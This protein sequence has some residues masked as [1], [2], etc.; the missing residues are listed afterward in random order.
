[1]WQSGEKSTVSEFVGTVLGLLIA[2][3]IGLPTMGCRPTANGPETSREETTDSAADAN[4]K[5][6]PAS[7]VTPQGAIR[8]RDVSE[9]TGI[10]FLHVDGSA[11]LR[12]IVESM[13]GGVATLDYDG[14]GLIDIY[15]PNGSTL[16]G[17]QPIQPPPRHALYRN[18]GDWKFKDVTVEAGIDCTTFGMGVTVGDFDN[19]G[20]PDIF[21]SNFGPNLLWHNNGDGTFA[22]IRTPFDRGVS[23]HDFSYDGLVGAGTSFVDVDSD[24]DL[25]LYVGNYLRLNCADH[26][27]RVFKGIPSY[28][29]PRDYDPVPDELFRNNG[30]GTFSDV[31]ESSG[32]A[33]HPGRAMGMIAADYDNDHDTD[34]FVCND[35]QQN[36]LFQ[37]DGTGHFEEVAALAGVAYNGNGQVLANMGV[38]AADYN[39]DGL[40][41]FFTTNYQGTVPVLFENLGGG[42]LTDVTAGT[43][44]GSGCYQDVNWG[45]GFA[46]LDNDGFKDLFIGNGHTEDNIEERMSGA[47]YHSHYIVLK[48]DGSKFVNVSDRCSDGSQR[49][50]A[51]KGLAIDDLDND[52]DPDLVVMASRESPMMLR[53]MYGE[54][55]GKHHWL[56]IQLIGVT[57]NRDGVGARVTV[58]VGGAELVD[59]VHSGRSYQ[60]HSGMRLHFGLGTEE[61]VEQVEVRWMGGGR[62]L[63]K[64]VAADQLL[65]IVQ[66]NG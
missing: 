58:T 61:Q 20:A 48:N 56:E 14:D 54:S 43:N 37:N 32:I 41:D 55:G 64:N 8:L 60:S 28:P 7:S 36:F 63:I 12:Y 23:P 44:A 57:G 47:V 51:A 45:C 62:Q 59:E 2:T 40:L 10:D 4:A 65:T 6:S 38:D 42:L 27:P 52:G 13:T 25:D 16:P 5:E 31:S 9:L 49:S 33:A 53:N 3:T 29:S 46:D 22:A 1:M 35:V 24:G 15:F 66:S 17:S 34:L 18:L 26:V 39:R 11:G 19:D 21:L 50:L 30:D